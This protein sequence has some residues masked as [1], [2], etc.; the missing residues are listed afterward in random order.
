MGY[1]PSKLF[2]TGLWD[3]AGRPFVF[4]WHQGAWI[5]HGAHPFFGLGEWASEPIFLTLSGNMLATWEVGS[6]IE[7][8][9]ARI[10]NLTRSLETYGIRPIRE[11]DDSRFAYEGRQQLRQ[12]FS[13]LVEDDVVG[14]EGKTKK[15]VKLL[16]KEEKHQ[17]ISICGMGGLGKTTL[18][19]KVYHQSE[20]R[21]H[22]DSFAWTYI[23]Q[24]CLAR[25]VFQGVLINLTSP[26]KEDKENI[27]Q[28][29]D[30]ELVKKL[31]QIQQEKKCL[32]ILDDLWTIQAWNSL[33]PAFPVGKS[34]SKILITTRNKDV[35]IHVDPKVL[36]HELQS[37]TE[38]ES[39]ELLQ[40]K[41][42]LPGRHG[43]GS[44]ISLPHSLPLYCYLLL[45]L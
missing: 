1:E 42:M 45:S 34:K 37:L 6:E 23:S 38:E 17:V 9:K 33:R 36:I 32:V 3:P 30:D 22:F 10:S 18:A 16:V 11:G 5:S 12:T 24:Q 4:R 26:T 8:I 28:L 27:L 21:R 39:W 29:R 40:K 7:D 31:Y 35:S 43:V 19:R 15:L 41:V 2:D 14:L 25:D 20:V 44:L 13:H